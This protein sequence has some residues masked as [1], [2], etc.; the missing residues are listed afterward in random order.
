[1]RDSS[2]ADG[3]TAA[4][5]CGAAMPPSAACSSVSS[6]AELVDKREGEGGRRREG[7]T[8]GEKEQ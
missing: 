8:E 5:C 1:M 7:R 2:P 4:G 3:M 6:A